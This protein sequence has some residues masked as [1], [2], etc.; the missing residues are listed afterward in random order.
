M[1]QRD[2][3]IK[4]FD[5]TA[6]HISTAGAQNPNQDLGKPMISRWSKEPMIKPSF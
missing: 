1:L 2:K 3:K 4:K 6:E 5:S